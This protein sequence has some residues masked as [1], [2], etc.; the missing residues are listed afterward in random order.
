M[1]QTWRLRAL[2]LGI[3]VF[4]M[5]ASYLLLIPN[6]APSQREWVSNA[7][8]YCFLGGLLFGGLGLILDKRYPH[9]FRWITP[10]T[11]GVPMVGLLGVLMAIESS[12]LILLGA[13][14][15]GCSLLVA[16]PWMR[17]A[18]PSPSNRNLDP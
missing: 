7:L 11:L 10:A 8:P 12:A 5:A 14:M 17:F 13:G 15:A 16:T 6:L 1:R 4:V 9:A 3:G 18:P 2:L